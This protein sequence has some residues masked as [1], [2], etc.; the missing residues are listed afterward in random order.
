MG[1]LILNHTKNGNIPVSAGWNLMK[2]PIKMAAA[3]TIYILVLT[4]ASANANPIFTS[5]TH[6]SGRDDNNNYVYTL[7]IHNASTGDSEMDSGLKVTAFTPDAIGDSFGFSGGSIGDYWNL[8]SADATKFIA[9]TEFGEGFIDPV[10]RDPTASDLYI[11]FSSPY[12]TLLN[13][14]RIDVETVEWGRVYTINNA[15]LPGVPEPGDLNLDAIVNFADFSIL[16][17]DWLAEESGLTADI[18]GD[19][20][21]DVLDLAIMAD[22]W[23]K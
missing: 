4:A 11:T 6:Y 5:D 9:N 18:N 16:A 17:N 14:Q 21:V 23:L 19:G 15:Q 8:I 12:N 2:L 1:A 7:H 13:N 3:V 20:V 10:A 22:Q